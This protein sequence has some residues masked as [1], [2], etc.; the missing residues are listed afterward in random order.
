LAGAGG[1]FAGLTI[2]FLLELLPRRI[3]NF[4]QLSSATGLSIYGG[5]PRLSGGMEPSRLLSTLNRKPAGPIAQSAMRLLKNADLRAGDTARSIVVA[6]PNTSVAKSGVALML[7]WAA[8]Q[9]GRSCVVVDIDI[10]DANLSRSLKLVN[11]KEQTT[12]VDVLY[13]NAEFEPAMRYVKPSGMHV[14]ACAPS[15]S[16][17]ALIFNTARAK[18]IIQHLLATYD[19]V[20]FDAPAM[21]QP[22][23]ALT[24]PMQF[25]V[26]LFVVESGKTLVNDIDTGLDVLS[27]TNFANT[28]TVLT[29]IPKFRT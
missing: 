29:N 8:N 24:L 21:T 28:G 12:F 20:I 19:T 18:T 25:D 4:D 17:P 10:R 6:G 3:A 9:K 5:V 23:D 14:V 26:G 16:D 2:A 7:G 11:R 22:S 1:L 15:G 27:E 13:H